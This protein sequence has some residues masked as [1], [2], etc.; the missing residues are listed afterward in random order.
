MV[1]YVDGAFATSRSYANEN[2][3]NYKKDG[4]TGIMHRS[5]CCL[6]YFGSGIAPSGNLL[7]ASAWTNTANQIIHAF[8][9]RTNTLA[10]TYYG[11][12]HGSAPAPGVLG[13]IEYLGSNKIAAIEISGRFAAN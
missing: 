9:T 8:D 7:Y 12:L 11:A 6:H 3:I 13:D 2:I 4:S 5:N 10:R 1:G